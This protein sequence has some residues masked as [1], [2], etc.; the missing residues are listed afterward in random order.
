GAVDQ[1]VT[2]V[3]DHV[4]AALGPGR[5]AGLQGGGRRRGRG[6]RCDRRRGGDAQNVT[7][8]ADAVGVA[9][10]GRAGVVVGVR[11]GRAAGQVRD[12][13][14]PALLVADARAGTRVVVV[15]AGVDHVV[16]VAVPVGIAAG[17]RRRV[18]VG[19]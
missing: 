8:V 7:L 16:L 6:G 17:G 19:A 1:A 15:G 11:D 5:N 14:N 13:A 10:G 12:F 4:G 3:V 18:A 2:V 9:A